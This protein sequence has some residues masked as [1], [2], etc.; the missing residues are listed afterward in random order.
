VTAEATQKLGRR[1]GHLALL[2]AVRVVFPAECNAT[3][4]EREQS[5]ISDGSPMNISAP[6]N[7]GFAYTTHY[8]AKRF[9]DDTR[10]FDLLVAY[11]DRHVL[12]RDRLNGRYEATDGGT[13]TARDVR[14]PAELP[15]EIGSAGKLR[16]LEAQSS[17]SRLTIELEGVKNLKIPTGAEIEVQSGAFY[18]RKRYE[19]VPVTFDL[20]AEDPSTRSALPGPMA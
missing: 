17:A 8:W 1:E 18:A 4:I 11:A 14:P 15:V 16:L 7:A 13:L 6:P 5:M 19:T 10:A 9:P 2:V 3:A 12:Y 20:A